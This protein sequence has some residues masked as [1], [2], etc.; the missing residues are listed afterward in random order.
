MS[1]CLYSLL[2]AFFSCCCL[3]DCGT[4]VEIFCIF[5]YS[6]SRLEE[7][8]MKKKAF[9][10][11]QPVDCF[12]KQLPCSALP[13]NISTQSATNEIKRTFK[14]ALRQ[15]SKE[16]ENVAT[17]KKKQKVW[18]VFVDTTAAAETYK[19]YMDGTVLEFLRSC[20]LTVHV[21]ARG[22]QWNKKQKQITILSSLLWKKFLYLV[23]F[24]FCYFFQEKMKLFFFS[25]PVSIR[26]DH[27]LEV[28]ERR[29]F[30]KLR[31]M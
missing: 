25:S 24:F 4:R 2:A 22:R 13:L 20:V 9:I 8:F 1:L 30:F 11:A 21:Y 7:L 5:V 15:H 23:K 10:S 17:K 3:D 28:R 27:D 6:S 31:Q 26:A 14:A 12:I 18:V 19:A 16:S 29:F